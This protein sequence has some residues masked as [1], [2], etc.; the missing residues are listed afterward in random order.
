[1][2]GS[3][4]TQRLNGSCAASQFRPLGAWIDEYAWALCQLLVPEEEVLFGEW[5]YARH[6]VPYTHLPGYFIAFDIYNKR[7][8]SFVSAEERQRRMA[9]LPIPQVHRVAAR[10][11]RSKDEVLALLETQSRYAER[12]LEGVYLRIDDHAAGGTRNV[13]RAKLVRPDFIQAIDAFWTAGGLVKNGVCTWAADE[14]EE[15]AAP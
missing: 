7:T 6:S 14:A 10:A 12:P 11:F 5:C 8:A 4:S 13:R 1:M 2:F 3:S 9:G 15:E